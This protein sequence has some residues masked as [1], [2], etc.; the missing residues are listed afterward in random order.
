M[1]DNC[2]GELT[3]THFPLAATSG[4]TIGNL[5]ISTMGAY[6]TMS[7]SAA[8]CLLLCVV[9]MVIFV[10]LPE[11]PH[12]FV[13]INQEDKA[14]LSLLW[15]H[16]SCDVDI[17]LQ[18]LKK[19]IEMN[20]SLSFVDVLKEFKNGYIRKALVL[21]TFLYMYS[22]LCGL[23]NIV[24]YMVIILESARVTV[25]KPA[26]IVII[27]TASG[28]VGSLLSMF[29]IDKFGRRILMINSSLACGMSIACLRVQFQLLDADYDVTVMQ[30]L[31]IIALL[32]Y[33][34]SVYVGVISVPNTVLGE[35]FPPHVKCVAVCFNS[36]VA[37]IFSFI[38]T[39][40]YQPLIDLITEKYVFFIY[41]AML[42]TA[43]PYTLFCVPETKGKSLQKIQE[44]LMKK[45]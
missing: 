42:L 44:E 34:I 11:S 1:P 31:P 2:T 33:Q 9:V 5:V 8:V 17:E 16:R 20:N 30:G 39:A 43:I 27:V 21:V 45:S 7:V 13:K 29:L 28:I 24:F 25:I 4:A 6:V 35:I 38:S 14:R 3:R 10:W 19:F 12:H 23:N 32:L 26:T 15:Y 41:A 18:A 22:M 40:T 37:S 36:I